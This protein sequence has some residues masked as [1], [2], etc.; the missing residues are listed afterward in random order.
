MLYFLILVLF[1]VLNIGKN[2]EKGVFINFFCWPSKD[3]CSN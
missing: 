1:M 2:V 3:N